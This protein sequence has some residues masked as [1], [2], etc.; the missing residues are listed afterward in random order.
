[1]KIGLQQ[2]TNKS[3]G[4]KQAHLWVHACEHECCVVIY[5]S[6]SM[7]KAEQT[8]CVCVC[9]VLCVYAFEYV[10][11]CGALYYFSYNQG[12]LSE[13]VR[14]SAEQ[15]TNR[16]CGSESCAGA[17]A[18]TFSTVISRSNASLYDD[19]ARKVIS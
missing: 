9:Y 4:Y 3:I 13:S 12:Y 10:R 17:F 1:M 2:I 19:K 14:H 18:F 15:T 5:L 6:E 11:F 7:H 16:A 8:T